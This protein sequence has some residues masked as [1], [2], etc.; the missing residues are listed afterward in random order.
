MDEDNVPKL[1]RTDQLRQHGVAIRDI[2]R[3]VD[4]D[5]QQVVST[6]HCYQLVRHSHRL[7]KAAGPAASV[8]MQSD[9]FTSL[10]KMRSRFIAGPVVGSAQLQLGQGDVTLEGVHQVLGSTAPQR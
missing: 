4:V 3:P 7:T 5:H 6:T 9:V 1:I 8:L 2:L 10:P